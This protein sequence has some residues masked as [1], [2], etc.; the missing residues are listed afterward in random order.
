[1][2][3]RKRRVEP[4]TRTVGR[5]RGAWVNASPDPGARQETSNVP[6]GQ[7]YPDTWERSSPVTCGIREDVR[8]PLLKFFSLT[9]AAAWTCWAASAAISRGTEQAGVVV[10]ALAGAVFL[11]GVFAPGLVGLALTERADGR[12]ATRALL[13]RVFKWQV[14][15]RWYLF[16]VGYIPAIK[17]SAALVHRVVTG[18][19]P[20]FGA[21]PVY[22]MA[23]ALLVST[24]VQARL[25]SS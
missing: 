24:W 10:E 11:L 4:F 25:P 8:R 6:A 19:W 15:A 9:Y 13:R 22:L 2:Y 23:V 16:A 18:A 5:P 21:E 1:V 7:R 20:R 12:E 3:E 14:D 17:L